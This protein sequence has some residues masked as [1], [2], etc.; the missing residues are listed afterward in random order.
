MAYDRGF[1]SAAAVLSVTNTY[2]GVALTASTALDGAAQPL[3]ASC[4]LEMLH[5][6]LSS[7][8]TATEVTWYLSLD[9]DGDVPLTG[10]ATES[11]QAGATTATDGAV[12]TRVSLEYAAPSGTAGTLYLWAK[13]DAGTCTL[14]PRLWWSR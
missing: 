14:L 3:P 11:I 13:T 12:A 6:A 10:E 7:V 5:G 1:T 2:S 8:S 4:L 9:S